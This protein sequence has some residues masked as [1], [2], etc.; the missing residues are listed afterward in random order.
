MNYIKH[1]SG[2]FAK[3]SKDDRLN[4][5]HVS[6]YVSLFQFWNA[7]RFHNPISI[8]RQEAMNVSKI[9]SKVTYHKCMRQL[10][11][12]GYL[13]YIPSY[14]PFKGSLVYLY[15]FQTGQV[16]PSKTNQNINLTSP[17]LAVDCHHTKNETSTVL[18]LIPYINNT[19]NTKQKTKVNGNS[20]IISDEKF[21]HSKNSDSELPVK[22]KSSPAKKEMLAFADTKKS[23]TKSQ[24]K[25][26]E[27]KKSSAA[28]ETE[29][30]TEKEI[31][32]FK[33]NPHNSVQGFQRPLHSETK[34]YFAQNNWPEKE[35]E[36]FHN[37][38]E[39]KGWLIG[40]APMA[41]WNAAANNWMINSIKFANDKKTNNAVKPGGLNTSIDKNYSEP[42]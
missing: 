10:H 42:L 21:N 23:T 18:A 9:S 2:F 36:K 13:N 20:K 22:G 32:I 30:S 34:I 1:L 6:L 19:N 26:R 31:S 33:N 7:C 35:A 41:N 28:A 5:T 38:Y 37:Y 12:F 17:V 16:I 11:E 14:N 4:P 29:I 3:V 40:N 15:D 8:S 24:Q 25:L 39:S 27:K